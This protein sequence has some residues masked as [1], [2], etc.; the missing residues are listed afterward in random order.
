MGDAIYK[1]GGEIG[2]APTITYS[3]NP[4]GPLELDASYTEEFDS[5]LGTGT[6]Q[7]L[8]DLSATN[9][10]L[11]VIEFSQDERQI[12]EN[13]LE[14]WSAVTGINFVENNQ[15]YGDLHFTKL[16]FDAYYSNTN[17]SAF[18]SGGLAF[19]PMGMGFRW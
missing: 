4:G 15:S 17:D 10:D 9:T 11:H 12:I 6:A 5:W 13:S 18:L 19:M 1:W 7:Y 2:T 8:E 14:S 16:D 3:F